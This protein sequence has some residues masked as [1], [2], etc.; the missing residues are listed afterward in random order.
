MLTITVILVFVL[1]NVACMHCLLAMLSQR[2][3]SLCMPCLKYGLPKHSIVLEQQLGPP[4]FEQPDVDRPVADCTI[5]TAATIWT[6]A[7]VDQAAA[8]Q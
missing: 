6:D 7:T 8:W 4:G 2:L 3:L 5:Q 1:L